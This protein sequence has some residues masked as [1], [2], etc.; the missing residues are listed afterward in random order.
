MRRDNVKHWGNAEK[1]K[2]KHTTHS[3]YC[4]NQMSIAKV[5]QDLQESVKRLHTE[6]NKEQFHFNVTFALFYIDHVARWM[7]RWY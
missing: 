7:F 1:G 4:Q 6:L 3:H 5:L 2:E